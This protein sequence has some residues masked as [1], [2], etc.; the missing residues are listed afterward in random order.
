MNVELPSLEEVDQMEKN[1]FLDAVEGFVLKKFRE[2]QNKYSILISIDDIKN[3][4][5]TEEINEDNINLIK[6]FF[7]KKGIKVTFPYT[8]GETGNEY[9]QFTISP[10]ENV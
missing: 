10:E 7:E 1:D 6:N 3:A 2:N 4:A 8:D 5:T 9:F